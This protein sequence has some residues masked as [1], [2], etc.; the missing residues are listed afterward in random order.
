MSRDPLLI[1]VAMAVIAVGVILA[2]GMNSMG[3]NGVEGAK[4]SNKLMQ[5]RIMAQFGAVVVIMIAILARG[6]G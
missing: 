4:R 1:I 6:E 2:I 5:W 3:K